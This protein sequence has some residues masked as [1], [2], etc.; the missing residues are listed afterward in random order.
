MRIT[1][2]RQANETGLARVCQSPRG[3]DGTGEENAY[4]ELH[5][6]IAALRTRQ[7]LDQVLIE[8]LRKRLHELEERWSAELGHANRHHAA[9][10]A[11]EDRLERVERWET[12]TS[13][14]DCGAVETEE[15]FCS[16]CG[17]PE[18]E[19]HLDDCPLHGWTRTT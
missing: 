9:L 13:H 15:N 18:G 16:C 11:A 2:K 17:A 7:D 4:D 12:V 10:R 6:Q 3:C 14:T 1:F 5:A 19:P 8:D